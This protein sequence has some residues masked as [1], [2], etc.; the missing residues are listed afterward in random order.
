MRRLLGV[1]FILLFGGLTSLTA[2]APTNFPIFQITSTDQAYEGVLYL[3]NFPREGVRTPNIGNFALAMTNQGVI[4][5]YQ[6][7]KPP[8]RAF[9]VQGYPDGTVTYYLPDAP[10]MGGRGGVGVQGAYYRVNSRGQTLATYTIQPPLQNTDLHD[11][12]LLENGNHLLISADSREMDLREYD[13]NQAAIVVTNS[14][15][16]ITPEGQVVWQWDGWEHLPLEDVVNAR[17]LRA[18]PPN[19][20]A[21]V[22][23]NSVALDLDG[24]LIVSLRNQNAVLKI[25]RVSGEVLWRLGGKR[26]DFTFLNDP[27][28]GF[29]D[30]HDATILENGHLLLF[31]NG[32][33]HDPPI[34]RAV[35]Y[36]LNFEDMTATLVWSYQNGQQGRSLGSAQRLPNGNT[37]ISWGSS[38][39]PQITEVTPQGD[40][41][42]EIRLPD[43][44]LT[45]RAYK[46]VTSTQ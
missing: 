45:Y 24:N 1:V 10:G 12:L 6:E 40:I 30:Q 33:Q 17:F 19:P 27:L 22:H 41:A 38:A 25:D 35:E 28:N 37:L 21:Y 16:E 15:Q 44:H 18:N 20:V 5:F 23:M 31:D 3:G 11:L 39:E 43:D 26:S 36:A 14:L 4:L 7:F 8:T 29:T 32:S 34:S 9:N 42:L 13:G 46:L 2:Q